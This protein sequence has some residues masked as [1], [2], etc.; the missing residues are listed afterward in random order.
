MTTDEAWTRGELHRLRCLVAR[1]RDECDQ[2]AADN[3]LLAD[4]LAAAVAHN[5]ADMEPDY[6][7]PRRKA[8]A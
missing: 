5:Y 6:T 3:R 4:Q 1:L 7:R 8:S 2:L